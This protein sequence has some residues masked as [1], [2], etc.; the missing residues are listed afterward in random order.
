[1]ARSLRG[2]LDPSGKA[3]SL[4]PVIGS[5]GPEHKAAFL[6][7]QTSKPPPGPFLPSWRNGS[8]AYEVPLGGVLA[9]RAWGLQSFS[10]G[11]FDQSS[12]LPSPCLAN[13]IF[14]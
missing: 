3:L 5:S 13:V 12:C 6:K 10:N 14:L 1:M 9:G 4:S 11:W 8:H 2:I 7:G